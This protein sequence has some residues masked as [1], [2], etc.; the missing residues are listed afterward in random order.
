MRGKE[1]KETK[2]RGMERITPACAGKRIA[3]VSGTS[4]TEDHPR[5]CGEKMESGAFH[6]DE[7]GSPPRVR[8]KDNQIAF[9]AKTFGIT[10][11]CAG[12]SKRIFASRFFIKDH[13]RVCGEKFT[14]ASLTGALMGSPPR[15]RGKVIT[16]IAGALI[17]R[18]TPACAGKRWGWGLF[19][20]W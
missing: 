2:A 15:V 5:V 10:P 11:A 7:V 13:P 3:T 9:L 4:F 8:G 18:I 6:P 20:R 16:A 19:L 17:L 12:K 1:V 14:G